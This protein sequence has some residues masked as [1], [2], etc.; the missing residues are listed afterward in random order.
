MAARDDMAL[1]RF[2]APTA[3]PDHVTYTHFTRRKRP[4]PKPSRR[5][6]QSTSSSRSHF[7]SSGT[8]SEPALPKSSA[9]ASADGRNSAQLKWPIGSRT[10]ASTS[11]GLNGPPSSRAVLRVS[12]TVG[13]GLAAGS[14]PAAASIAS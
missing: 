4:T 6:P 8:D 2:T 5:R 9:V 3:G 11:G 10:A 12:A 1:A 13:A 7:A 14:T